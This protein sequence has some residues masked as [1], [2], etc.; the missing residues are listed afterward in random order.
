MAL[1]FTFAYVPGFFEQDDLNAD[2]N[3]I[4]AVSEMWLAECARG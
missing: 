1:N 2:P 4:G 3:V